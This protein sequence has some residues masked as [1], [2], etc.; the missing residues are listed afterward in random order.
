M[1]ETVTRQVTLGGVVAT[2]SVRHSSKSAFAAA[3]SGVCRRSRSG[4]DTI[5]AKRTS[6]RTPASCLV[7][8]L[9]V[10]RRYSAVDGDHHGLGALFLPARWP[11]E[12]FSRVAGA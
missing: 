4:P 3:T 10:P 1:A 7:A 5:R 2:S 8:E 11:V 9:T 12:F 6:A